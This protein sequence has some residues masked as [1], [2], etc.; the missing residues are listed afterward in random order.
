M[1]VPDLGKR[2]KEV[3][4]VFSRI[5]EPGFNLPGAAKACRTTGVKLMRRMTSRT[6]VAVSG[7]TAGWS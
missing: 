5:M 3:V 1:V 7:E 6:A 2:R 4:R